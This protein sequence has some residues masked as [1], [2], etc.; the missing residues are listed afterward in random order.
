MLNGM[1]FLKTFADQGPREAAFIQD[2]VLRVDQYDGGVVLVAVHGSPF[3]SGSSYVDS[4]VI[5]L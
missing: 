5:A 4:A 1:I 3:D 2:L